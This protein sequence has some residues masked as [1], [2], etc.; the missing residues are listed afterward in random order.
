MTDRHQPAPARPDFRVG[1]IAM[2]TLVSGTTAFGLSG[3]VPSSLLAL[4]AGCG[5]AAAGFYLDHALDRTRD[6]LSGNGA[7]PLASGAMRPPVAIALIAV[8]L[9][10]AVVPALFVRPLTLIPVAL[11]Q[12]GVLLLHVRPIETPLVRAAGLGLL[13]AFYVFLGAT[14]AEAPASRA[15]WLAAFLFFAMTGGKALGDVRDLGHDRRSGARTIPLRFGPNFTRVFLLI[16]EAAAYSI[17]IAAYFFAGFRV[18]F[19]YAMALTAGAGTVFNI[20]FC[21]APTPARA[22][23]VNALSLGVLGMLYVA[24]MMVEGIMRRL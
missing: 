12:G 1:R 11:V 23:L 3:D 14:W 18:F 2:L 19:L 15:I 7:N 4:C 6:E 20:Y 5:A 8:G 13:Q 16:N 21:L 9:A 24:A 17:G 22:R 10:M